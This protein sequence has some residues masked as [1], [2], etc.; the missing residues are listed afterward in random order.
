MSL[1]VHR[2]PPPIF[3]DADADDERASTPVAMKRQSFT[4]YADILGTEKGR[5]ALAE[6]LESLYI[7]NWGETADAMCICYIRH[8]EYN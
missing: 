3:A 4:L 7:D 5:Q 8:L 2:K 1:R 6:F